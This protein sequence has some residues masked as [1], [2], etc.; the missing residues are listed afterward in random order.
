MT[1]IF[2]DYR[3][4][5]VLDASHCRFWKCT[6]Q[7]A[8]ANE[9]FVEVN[10]ANL[11]CSFISCFFLQIKAAD[12]ICFQ[13]AKEG[14]Q[15]RCCYSEEETLS[16]YGSSSVSS[17]SVNSTICTSSNS[18]APNLCCSDELS[19][20]F[21]NHSY[22]SES[23]RVSCYFL[24]FTPKKEDNNC[25][26]SGCSC[27]GAYPVYHGSNLADC[28]LT[29]FNL[30]NNTDS[31]GYVRPGN[32]YRNRIKESVISF[33]SRG[34]L[35]W[36]CPTTYTSATLSLE[37]CFV[38]ASSTIDGGGK[39][40]LTSGTITTRSASTHTLFPFHPQC[41]QY[42]KVTFSF[43][44]SVNLSPTSPIVFFFVVP[45]LLA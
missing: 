34:S 33:K 14:I 2:A 1:I 30:V 32:P 29:K 16:A 35:K 44:Q 25:F 5:L 7:K 8:T 6:F 42:N 22:L 17:L 20:F 21:N 11:F 45:V 13:S 10:D 40:T 15:Q 24:Y 38:V 41:S 3:K 36:L 43:S 18:G 4:P 19:S 39:V 12:V 23:S 37:G 28:V 27:D 9:H 31:N 26:F